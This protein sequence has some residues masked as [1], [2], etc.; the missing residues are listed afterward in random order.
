MAWAWGTRWIK[1]LLLFLRRE[2]NVVQLRAKVRDAWCQVL[3]WTGPS[4]EA[5][6]LLLLIERQLE[7]VRN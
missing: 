2:I 1:R 7:T 4:S 5:E 6:S 3:N